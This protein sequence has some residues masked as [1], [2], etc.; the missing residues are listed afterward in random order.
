MQTQK[1]IKKEKS[2]A[3]RFPELAKEWHVILNGEL[4]PYDVYPYSQIV[5][6]WRTPDG[7]EFESAIRY[8]TSNYVKLE[9]N[10]KTT[11]TAEPENKLNKEESLKVN[12]LAVKH[13]EIA[14]EWDYE[15]N[16]GVTPYDIFEKSGKSYWFKCV[17]G[18]SWK[19]RIINRT[20]KKSRCPYCVL[21]KKKL[22]Y[23]RPD[24]AEEFDPIKNKKINLFDLTAS[25]PDSVYWICKNCGKKYKETVIRRT[26][27]H[28]CPKCQPKKRK[29]IPYE[30]SLEYNYPDI[31]KEWDYE[32]NKDLTPKDVRPMS[33]ISVFWKCIIDK[34][35][36]SW[37]S[38]IHNRTYNGNG[39]PACRY[40]NLSK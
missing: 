8:R 17:N 28:G 2:L 3:V 22:I 5:V 26:H 20:S 31:A 16:A 19:A 38:R 37:K 24:I 11:Q 40:R 27:D 7:R 18:H 30:N 33:G 10:K 35:H 29:P 25:S 39:C 14:A 13:P 4:T 21:E 9:K 15:K 32:L 34:E 12:N 23:T 36:P 6:W 1:T